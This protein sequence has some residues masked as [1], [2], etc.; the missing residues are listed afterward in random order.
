MGDQ[1]LEAEVLILPSFSVRT[2]L[3]RLVNVI[4]IMMNMYVPKK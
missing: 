4:Y 3:C 2:L 1:T